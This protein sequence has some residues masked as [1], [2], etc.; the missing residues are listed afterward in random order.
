MDSDVEIMFVT[1]I[2][3]LISE[4]TMCVKLSK[5]YSRRTLSDAEE[6]NIDEIWAKRLEENPR[7]FNG[8]KF[9]IHSVNLDKS[10]LFT[11]NLSLTDYKEYL[12]TN[13]APNAKDLQK[14]GNVKFGDSQTCLSDPLGVGAFVVTSDDHA[15]FLRRSQHCAEAPDMWDIPGGHAEP[16][17]PYR[18]WVMVYL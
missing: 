16:E 8:T 12:G 11:M 14:M 9:R 5:E 18:F 7:I 15:I 1:E 13:W 3:K 2:G 17:V 6:S 10:G 4:Q